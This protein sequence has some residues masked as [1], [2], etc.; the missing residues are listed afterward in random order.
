M[1][2]A[3][4][5]LMLVG[6]MTTEMRDL[7]NAHFTVHDMPKGDALD[8]F[9]SEKGDMLRPVIG[10]GDGD[11]VRAL[12]KGEREVRLKADP[13]ARRERR[14]KRAAKGGLT[15]DLSERDQALFEALRSWRLE[16]AKTRGVPP[17]VIFHDRTLA[18]IAA[19]R[20]GDVDGLRGISGVGEKKAERF[21]EAVLAVVAEGE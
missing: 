17:Y 1:P 18:A 5:D 6:G 8:A 10:L 7:L 11:D 21:G 12:W 2:E 16:E 14:S 13:A 9:L 3:K 15:A 19:E 20:P 4:P